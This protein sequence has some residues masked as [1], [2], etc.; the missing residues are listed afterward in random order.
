MLLNRKGV[1]MSIDLPK[2]P[3]QK[4]GL[5]VTPN[6]NDRWNLIIG[7]SIFKL[8]SILKQFSEID[9]FIHDSA[10]TYHFQKIEVLLAFKKLKKGGIIIINNIGHSNAFNEIIEIIKPHKK[11]VLRQ[12][13]KKGDF[14]GVIIK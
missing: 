1:L 14:T 11:F 7:S 12:E 4:V 5:Y 10:N 8:K 3:D 9:M 6:L 13:D 2:Y